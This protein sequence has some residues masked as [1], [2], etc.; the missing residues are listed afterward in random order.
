M[1]RFL[2]AA[3]V[4]PNTNISEAQV[5]QIR[6]VAAKIPTVAT[7]FTGD[8]V[9]DSAPLVETPT[10]FKHTGYMPPQE[11]VTYLGQQNATEVIVAGGM[12]DEVVLA[13]GIVLH[14]A[15]LKPILVPALCYGNLWYEHSVTIRL[16]ENAIGQVYENLFELGL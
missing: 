4:Q 1:T 10:I 8:G 16:W 6:G 5:Q 9:E 13:N 7:L 15:G 14:D 11:L 2:L 3:D 12:T